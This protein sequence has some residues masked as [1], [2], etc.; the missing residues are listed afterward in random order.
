[1]RGIVDAQLPTALARSL[2][3]LG[4]DVIHVA[5]VGLTSAT[6]RRIWNFAVS[7]QRAIITKDEDFQGRR[8]VS[9]SGPFVVWIRLGNLRKRSLIERI[10]RAW[11]AVVAA[12]ERG[13]ALV[14]VI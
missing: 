3:T 5:D 6:D 8:A 12:D 4:H 11:P 10:V 13:E 9:S 14:E 1:M 7:E 2:S